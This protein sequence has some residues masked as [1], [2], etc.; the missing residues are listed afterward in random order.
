MKNKLINIAVNKHLTI[1]SREVAKMLKKEHGVSSM[2]M[3]KVV[4]K[5]GRQCEYS[6]TGQTAANAGQLDGKLGAGRKK[7][8]RSI[9][10]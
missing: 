7:G 3:F 4:D 1:D 2:I 5:D 10:S 8:D 9:C 6:L